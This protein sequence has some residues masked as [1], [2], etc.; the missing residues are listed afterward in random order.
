[1]TTAV[2]EMPAVV[3]QSTTPVLHCVLQCQVHAD[4]VGPVTAVCG[5]V[6]K[7]V[8]DGTDDSVTPDEVKCVV[9][10]NMLSWSEELSATVCGYC[11]DEWSG[12]KR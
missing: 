11:L 6:A 10:S 1:M 12:V 2:E 4:S 3:E 9:C 5:H 8:G 7:N